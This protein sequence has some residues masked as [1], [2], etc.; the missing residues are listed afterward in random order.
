M[1]IVYITAAPVNRSFK[2]HVWIQLST[3]G[4][5]KA[6]QASSLCAPLP[7]IVGMRLFFVIA[8]SAG[9]VAAQ[10]TSAETTLA[11]QAVFRVRCT[12]P[13]SVVANA[14]ACHR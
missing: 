3:P 7:L 4:V 5:P 2:S 12:W 13:V 8:I 6:S 11:L 9:A 10:R 14:I 1:C